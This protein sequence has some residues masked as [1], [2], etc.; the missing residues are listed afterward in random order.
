MNELDW[1]EKVWISIAIIGFVLLVAS[2]AA[3]VMS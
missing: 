3:I 2:I 1:V